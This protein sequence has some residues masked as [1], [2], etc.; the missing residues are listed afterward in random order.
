MSH[1]E[2]VKHGVKSRKINRTVPGRN[3]IPRSVLKS[4]NSTVPAS[5]SLVTSL[6]PAEVGLFVG[7]SRRSPRYRLHLGWLAMVAGYKTL[8]SCVATGPAQLILGTLLPS[9]TGVALPTCA[10]HLLCVFADL[11]QAYPFLSGH[12]RQG[13]RCC[14]Q[15]WP[16]LLSFRSNNPALPGLLHRH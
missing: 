1:R 8:C 12:P 2:K 5:S 13:L 3:T 10:T 14:H 7:L 11:H 16:S 6:I 4:P 15:L 9:M